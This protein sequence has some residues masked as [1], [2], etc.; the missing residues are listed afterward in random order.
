MNAAGAAVLSELN[1]ILT[2]KGGRRTALK[3]LLGKKK[4]TKQ[5][6]N[7]CFCFTLN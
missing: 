2:S 7:I 4:K 3:A 6:Y 5:T 1:G